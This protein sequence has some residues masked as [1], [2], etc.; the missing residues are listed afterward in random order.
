VEIQ[1]LCD[2][3][4]GAVHLGER[5]LLVQRRH[6]KLV[7]ETPARC[8][9]SGSRQRMGRRRYAARGAPATPGRYVRVPGRPGRNYYF[10]EVNC[11]IQVEHPVTGW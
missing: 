1:I 8:L 3:L 4:G 5:G 7:E 6:Q 11:R 9:P 10:M 2:T